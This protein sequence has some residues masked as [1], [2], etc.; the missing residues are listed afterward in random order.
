M[1]IQALLIINSNTFASPRS[2]YQQTQLL[3]HL[4][5]KSKSASLHLGKL[6]LIKHHSNIISSKF[7]SYSTK[8]QNSY[9]TQ[10]SFV[11]KYRDYIA[12]CLG[13]IAQALIG[14][15]FDTIKVR[16]Q[17][18]TGQIST[19]QCIGNLI[20][21]EGPLAFYKGIGSPLICMSGVV[22][23][24]FGVFQRVVNSFQQAQNTKFLSTFQMGVCGSI[25]GLFACSVLSPMEHIRIRLQVMQN[26]IYNGAIDCAKKI[27]LD[28][29]LRGIY[30]GLT[31]TCLREVPALFAYFGSYHGVLRAIQGAYNNNQQELAVKCAPL[32]AGAVAGIAYCTFT[33]PID[34]IKSRI[35]TDN[36]VNPK[37]NGIVDGFRKTIKAQGF[38]SL[39]KGY[40]I[41]FVRGIPVNAASFLIFENVK[42][43]IEE[44]AMY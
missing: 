11:F 23:I 5:I 36:F 24:Q 32:V 18:S 1:V 33:Y 30:K 22:S 34:T 9:I 44:N 21:N 29:G 40:G 41:T 12:G 28:H 26:S 2:H 17:S 20:K 13:G 31:I 43:L 14:Q 10:D 3:T 19:G 25:A 35:Q 8:A 7:M 38:A 15:P 37:Y 16:L 42:A 4:R 27:Y 39:Y 6:L